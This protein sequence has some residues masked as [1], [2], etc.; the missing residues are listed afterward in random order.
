MSERKEPV[1]Q[2]PLVV[3]LLSAVLA[4]LLAHGVALRDRSQDREAQA[5]ALKVAFRSEVGTL[6]QLLRVSARD[7]MNE[8]NR[9]GFPVQFETPLLP[10]AVFDASVGQLGALRDADLSGHLVR[11]YTA[12]QQIEDAKRRAEKAVTPQLLNEY[13]TYLVGAFG[14]ASVLDVAL[15]ARTKNVVDQNWSITADDQ[16]AADDRF[17]KDAFERLK[18]LRAPDG[19]S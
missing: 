15:T 7:A 8:V 19:G 3:A 12:L 1:H 10:H 6:R 17:V 11:L 14:M 2:S 4:A 5:E 18:M 9:P 13:V 16:Y